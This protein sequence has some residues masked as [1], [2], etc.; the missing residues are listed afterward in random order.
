MPAQNTTGICIDDED[1][2]STRVEQHRVSRLRSD[3]AH[4]EASEAVWE[5]VASTLPDDAGGE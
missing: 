5:L 2:V 1:R 4:R 3:P